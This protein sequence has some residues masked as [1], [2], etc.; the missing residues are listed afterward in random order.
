[1]PARLS[2]A[3]AARTAPPATLTE[4]AKSWAENV[5]FRGRAVKTF[6][7]PRASAPTSGPVAVQRAHAFYKA[8]EQ[9]DVGVVRLYE[10]KAGAKNVFVVH[11]QTDGDLGFVELFS[12]KGQLLASGETSLNAKRKQVITWDTT[13]GQVR[14]RVAPN[15]DSAAISAFAAALETAKQPANGRSVTQRELKS[16]T[17]HLVGTELTSNSV[18]GFERVVLLKELAQT[19]VTAAARADGAALAALYEEPKAATVTNFTKASLGTSAFSSRVEVASGRVTAAAAPARIHT[20]TAFAKRAFERMPA[21][22]VPVSRADAQKQLRD[23]GATAAEA[24][25]TLAKLPGQLFSGRLFDD[26]QVIPVTTGSVLF[27]V[28]GRSLTAASVRQPNGT[29]PINAVPRAKV[30]ELLGVD[31]DVQ[32]LAERTTAAGKAYDLRWLP[33]MG[34][35]MEATLSVPNQ[36]EATFSALKLA[37]AQEAALKDNL[38][39]RV[40]TFLGTPR[41]AIGFVGRDDAQG[42]AFV[43]A[44]RT[45]NSM[46]PGSASLVR[47]IVGGETGAVTTRTFGPQDDGLMRDLALH[48]ARGAAE[49]L[50]TDAGAGDDARIEVA[51]RTRWAQ[52]EA[53]DPDDSPPG[54]SKTTDQAQ[55]QLS[56]VW[57]DNTVF[58]TFAKNGA[59][60][61][62]FS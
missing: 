12:D 54:F 25:A 2:A 46:A 47:V 5:S 39:Q 38:S 28:D 29:P 20:M 56:R 37:P 4:A 52:V 1:M 32:V 50:V 6:E 49:R 17:Q 53:V 41:E 7:V 42:V 58:V 16:A 40:S 24:T 30:A 10:A 35:T 57:G 13:P 61:V 18:D 9:T 34:G 11:A 62:D 27:G 44:H 23:A 51:L 8:W 19:N 36:G 43:V 59:V 3:G 48:I 31:R 55:Y 45:P 15:D 60:R 22:L 26:S 21:Q 14:E 33:P